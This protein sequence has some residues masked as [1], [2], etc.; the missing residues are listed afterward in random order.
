V[1]ALPWL[2][3]VPRGDGHPVLVLPGLVASDRS[4]RLLRHFLAGRGYEVHGWGLGRNYGPRP[5]VKKRCSR[6]STG[7]TRRAAAS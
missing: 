1:T 5:G 3:L 2:R 4:T 7:C 6:S